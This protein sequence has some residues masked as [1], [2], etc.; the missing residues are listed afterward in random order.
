MTGGYLKQ[1]Q[2][3]KQL[4]EQA[5]KAAKNRESAEAKITES[6]ELIAS[7][8][9]IGANAAKA[10]KLLV[11]AS[12]S[13]T[14]KDYK[15]AL[16]QAVQSIELAL[17]AKAQKIEDILNSTQELLDGMGELSAE[18]K[19][20]RAAIGKARDLLESGEIEEAYSGTNAAW[21][22]TERYINAKIAD[23]FER[24]QSLLL[25]VEDEDLNTDSEREQLS[26][27]R[28]SLESEDF[29]A[30]LDLLNSCLDSLTEALTNLFQKRR[31]ELESG[32]EKVEDIEID[33]S[34][35]REQIE[36]ADGHLTQVDMQNAF[37]ELT[38]AEGEF[39][40]SFSRALLQEFNALESRTQFLSG[41]GEDVSPIDS[42]IDNGRKLTRDGEHWEAHGTFQEAEK[43]VGEKELGALIRIMYSLKPKLQIA[44]RTGNDT[45]EALSLLEQS[46]KVMREGDFAS[47]ASLAQQA[48][49]VLEKQL[50]GFREVEREL[51]VTENLMFL[52]KG[53]E[54]DRSK[55]EKSMKTARRFALKGLFEESMEQLKVAQKELN[56]E[57]QQHLGSEIMRT[58]LLLASAIRMGSNVSKESAMIDDI[59]ARV[60]SGDYSDVDDPLNRCR[61]SVLEFLEISTKEAITHARGLIEKYQG[62]ADVTSSRFML[63]KARTAFD[64]KEFDK[65]FKLAGKAVEELESR[66]TAVLENGLNEAKRLLEINKALGEESTTINKKFSKADALR[67]DGDTKEAITAVNEVLQLAGLVVKD[68]IGKGLNSISRSLSAA[69]KK[70]VVVTKIERLVQRAP[71]YLER[72]NVADAYDTL[73]E[74]D[75]GLRTTISRYEEVSEYL[76]E[77]GGFLEEAASSGIDIDGPDQSLKE[78]KTL[79]ESGEY[80]KA[81]ELAKKTREDAEVKIGPFMSARILQDVRNLTATAKRLNMDVSKEEAAMRRG[82]SLLNSK[83]YNKALGMSKEIRDEVRGRII[84]TLEAEITNA[85]E[86]IARA[87][88]LGVDFS[89]MSSIV[90]RAE[91]LL[92]EGRINDTLRAI[93]L[94]LKELDQGLVIERKAQE[95][96]DRAS[97][98]ISNVRKADFDPGGAAEILKQAKEQSQAGRHGIALELAK[99]SA[100]HAA[101]AARSR[102]MERFKNLEMTQRAMEIEGSDLAQASRMKTDFRKMIEEWKFTGAVTVLNNLEEEF[103]RV[104]K[105]KKL[106]SQTIEETRTRVESARE[107]GLV[108]QKVDEL[109]R[110]ATERMEEGGFSNAFSEAIRCRDELRSLEDLYDRRRGD[111]ERLSE[112]MRHAA[113]MGIDVSSAEGYFDDAE[114]LLKELE[115]EEASLN[116]SRGDTAL[117]KRIGEILDLRVRELSTLNDLSQDMGL[118]GELEDRVSALLTKKHLELEDFESLNDAIRLLEDSIRS[119]LE[120]MVGDI[121]GKVQVASKSGADVSTSEYLLSQVRELI[122]AGN[123]REA[124]TA[125]KEA[126]GSIGVALEERREFMELKMRCESLIENARRNGLVMESVIELFRRAEEER[127][128]DYQSAIETLKEAL[129]RAEEE[130][131]SYLPELAIGI[132]FIDKPV[133]GKW[134]RTRL[135]VTNETRAMARDVQIELEGDIEVRGL[136][137]IKKLRGNEEMETEIEIMPLHLGK[138]EVRLNLSCRPVLSEDSFGFDS[139]FELDVE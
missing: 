139:S 81:V 47:A 100:D 57:I 32:F 86:M 38:I 62:M 94:V 66:E 65:A 134:M 74:A 125:V 69:Q 133:S 36:K 78:T 132:D 97:A 39:R 45:S 129:P 60:R 95:G 4:E 113:D 15:G 59:M 120:S 37:S 79:F 14:R 18:A 115:F 7:A 90:D 76:E 54:L 109:L 106:A 83:D 64:S 67:L 111:Q 72:G 29:M 114:R 55:A 43:E 51:R 85:R 13:Y 5:K 88:D 126:E 136:E 108:S 128:S 41:Y 118:E 24:A 123:L 80:E 124:F 1:L 3:T 104:E 138:I 107:R 61:M 40:K 103:K 63:D 135:V 93:E 53:Y 84:Q 2:L 8:K 46:K 127:Q 16:S 112:K 70:G 28:R 68:H 33:I 12:E 99:K 44:R 34:R 131:A 130:A 105:Q 17:E 49:D 52:A 21:D 22:V 122:R 11:E 77:I 82:Q 23:E 6:E 35:V 73:Q 89:A 116:L 27:A 20:P 58:E 101:E 119:R 121:M 91:N 31:Q 96:I 9:R 110:N 50:T 30:S 19:E 102:L 71:K 87:D 98:I 56:K 10:E 48:D 92:S 117:N 26:Q 75:E 42:S 25:L 137:G